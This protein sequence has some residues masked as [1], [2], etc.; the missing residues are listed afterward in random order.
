M[1][2][3]TRTKAILLVVAMLSLPASSVR[4]EDPAVPLQLQADLTAKLIEYAQAPSP[5]GLTTL[6]IGILVRNGS[7]E[8][9]HFGSE[10]KA[11]FGRMATIAGMAHE[12]SVH[13]LVDARGLCRGGSAAPAVRRLCHARLAW[14]GARHRACPGGCADHLRRRDR[15]VRRE[16]CDP[17]I[18]ARLGTS[19]DGAEPSSGE[20]AGRRVSG[21][22]DEV[23]AHR[24]VTRGA[25]LKFPGATAR[26]HH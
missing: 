23:D 10:I 15:H 24:R 26:C 18:R 19:P 21:A 13:H 14:R 1:A 12:E 7:V 17:G 16:R 4:A 20:E 9:Q 25:N 22:G 8:S 11:I 6:R 3:L 5:Q 2:S